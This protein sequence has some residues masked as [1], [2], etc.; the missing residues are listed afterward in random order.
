L[1]LGGFVADV[2][3]GEKPRIILELKYV[4][5]WAVMQSGAPALKGEQILDILTI[6]NPPVIPKVGDFVSFANRHNWT[7]V[8]RKITYHGSS[9]PDRQSLVTVELQE[10]ALLKLVASYTES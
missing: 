2:F 8:R 1:I 4:G 5:V 3:I 10:P 9:G 6:D 7:A